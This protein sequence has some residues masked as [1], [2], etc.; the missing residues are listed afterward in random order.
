VTLLPQCPGATTNIYLAD[1]QGSTAH[2]VF[3]FT[4]FPQLCTP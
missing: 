2:N 1:D 3:S 4:G